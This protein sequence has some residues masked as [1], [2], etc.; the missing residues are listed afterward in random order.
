MTVGLAFLMGGLCG[1]IV[2]ASLVALVTHWLMRRVTR[3]H[4][5]YQARMVEEALGNDG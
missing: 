1:A 2:V 3:S 4:E 5:A